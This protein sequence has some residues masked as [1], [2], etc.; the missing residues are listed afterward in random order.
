MLSYPFTLNFAVENKM[1]DQEAMIFFNG[2]YYP[3]SGILPNLTIQPGQR[4]HQEEPGNVQIVPSVDDNEDHVD[5]V[6]VVT[7]SVLPV[8]V[9]RN[10]AEHTVQIEKHV[11]FNDEESPTIERRYQLLKNYIVK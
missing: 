6:E 5:V 8:Q 9:A 7:E 1:E 11:N 3:L 4:G 2:K 10:A